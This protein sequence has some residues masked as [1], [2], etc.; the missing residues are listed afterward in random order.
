MNFD[1]QQ[2]VETLLAIGTFTL[3]LSLWIGGIL[4]WA[5]HHMSR[6]T[7][8]RQRLGI[9]ARDESRERVIKLWLDGKEIET[10]VHAKSRATTLRGKVE[11]HFD[12]AGL[13]MPF[14]HV[15]ALILGS[16]ILTGTFV[17]VV[18]G[19][20]LLAIGVIAVI[21][22]G[23]RIFMVSRITRRQ[24][25]FDTQLV[26][27]LELAARSLRAGHPLLGAF[28][29]LADEMA[30]PVST[31]FADVCQQHGLGADL[32][33]VL[34]EAGERSGSND[35]R[36]FATSVAMQLRTGGNLADLMER[37][38]IVMR[39]RMRLHRRVRILTAQTQVSKRVLL[40]LPF[41]VFIV[42]NVLNPKYMSVFYTERAGTYML[43]AGILM[44]AMGAWVMNK[45]ARLKY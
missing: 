10:T 34:R 9:E 30:P 16:V 33:R 4:L 5:R 31:I 38:A 18:T 27:A 24:A 28:Q 20:L 44:L 40:A 22:V 35:M 6:Q 25:M 39:D 14:L 17:T 1:P 37:L 13:P 43:A 15:V 42:F 41:I 23:G 3:V 26:D 32:E 8:V 2:V 21:L 7:E 29:L 45:M 11:H 19:K 36:I 12:R